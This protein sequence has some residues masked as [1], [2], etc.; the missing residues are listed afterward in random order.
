MPR[1]LI[2]NIVDN[3]VNISFAALLVKVTAKTPM[4]DICPVCISQAMRVVRTLVLPLPA[5]AS[6][7]ADWACPLLLWIGKVTACSCSGFKWW[8]S[9]VTRSRLNTSL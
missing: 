1:V 7:K 3:L 4:G 2:G 9:S 5:P 6:I 8:R